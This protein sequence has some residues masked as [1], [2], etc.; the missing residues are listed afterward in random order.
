MRIMILITGAAGFIGSCLIKYLNKN[1]ITNIC[2]SDKIGYSEKWR[3]LKGLSY[4]DWIERDKLFEWMDE[5]VKSITII[6]HLGGESSTLKKDENHFFQKNYE[7]SKK[8]YTIAKNNKI[9][10][11]Y[12]SS[13]STYGDGKLGY[14]DYLSIEEQMLLKPT[15][16]YG[17]SKKMIDDY[18]FKQGDI[19]KENIIGLKFF[20]VYGPN[21]YHKGKAKSMVLQIFEKYQNNEEIE[22]FDTKTLE[23]PLGAQRDFIYIE[24]VLQIIKFFMDKD[25]PSGLYNVGTGVSESFEKLAYYTVNALKP[26]I[27]SLNTIVKFIQMPIELRGNYQY[28]TNADISKLRNVGYDKEFYCLKDGIEEYVKKYLVNQEFYS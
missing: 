6:V 4:S 10:F 27:K 21:E 3:N 15:N 22:L 12:A 5:N 23:F 25:K 28:Y 26:N 17:L 18:I 16:E 24:D 8:L 19:P 2:I 11:I 14:S 13:A 20:N 7:Y 9:K 1:N